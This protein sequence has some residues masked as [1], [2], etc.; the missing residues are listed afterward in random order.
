MPISL[1]SLVEAAAQAEA[2]RLRDLRQ[3]HPLSSAQN[4]SGTSV[5]QPLSPS[6]PQDDSGSSNPT[7]MDIPPNWTG[8]Y[9]KSWASKLDPEALTA[10]A[11]QGLAVQCR[12]EFAVVLAS[13]NHHDM[14]ACMDQETVTELIQIEL[15]NVHFA[16]T[17]LGLSSS[18]I[19]P[20]LEDFPWFPSSSTTAGQLAHVPN[21]QI[22]D[23]HGNMNIDL[24]ARE[25]YSVRT[26]SP[27]NS[28]K[29]YI[30]A[31]PQAENLDVQMGNV[32]NSR[33]GPSR[34]FPDAPIPAPQ[35]PHRELQKSQFR[36][37][38]VARGKGKVQ[39]SMI[40]NFEAGRARPALPV[41]HIDWRNA[42][43]GS[44]W[45]KAVVLLLVQGLITQYIAFSIDVRQERF[46]NK[47]VKKR[48]EHARSRSGP[49]ENEEA[50]DMNDGEL[51]AVIAE[52]RKEGRICHLPR[53]GYQTRAKSSNRRAGGPLGICRSTGM[54]N[55]DVNNA[56]LFMMDQGCSSTFSTTFIWPPLRRS[57][58]LKEESSDRIQIGT[59]A[60]VERYTL[61]HVSQIGI[62]PAEDFV[63]FEFGMRGG[64]T[65]FTLAEQDI[66]FCLRHSDMHFRLVFSI[67]YGGP[68]N[69]PFLLHAGTSS[70]RTRLS[71]SLL[72]SGW[73]FWERRLREAGHL[74]LLLVKPGAPIL[75]LL[76]SF[77]L[78]FT[79]SR[80]SLVKTRTRLRLKQRNA[81]CLLEC[82]YADDHSRVSVE[83]YRDE[84]EIVDE[85]GPSTAA[86]FEE[87]AAQLVLCLLIASQ[88][89][90]LSSFLVPLAF[91]ST[92]T[93]HTEGSP[94]RMTFFS[95][96]KL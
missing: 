42:P 56:G 70:S 5:N 61:Q 46:T 28:Q 63:P 18:I 75:V 92:A 37:F 58:S 3:A 35:A 33:P 76:A 84:K 10:R 96:L 30:A 69:R 79:K 44:S 40:D 49:E 86:W 51:N 13:H 91:L 41:V 32:P 48:I 36:K 54:S 71:T 59:Q 53:D 24:G 89:L 55:S 82:S 20:S 87:L 25:A 72:G 1:P 22:S 78:L 81:Q 64:Y 12:E 88:R 2:D 90:L 31:S 9:A 52:P 94:D 83:D 66:A 47:A 62:V 93:N 45:N 67:R 65:K 6:H 43:Q 11:F 4:A 19:E 57:L 8:Q 21:A 26:P 50:G 29:N 27:Y 74:A 68:R 34:S 7:Q 77:E 60:V 38:W 17:D 15:Q 23:F 39:L 73:R 80:L 16:K 85:F 95:S 14:I